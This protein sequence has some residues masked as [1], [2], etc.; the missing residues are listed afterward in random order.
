[1]CRLCLSD[2]THSAGSG[3]RDATLVLDPAIVRTFFMGERSVESSSDGRHREHTHC[4][5]TKYRA[6]GEKR[7]GRDVDKQTRAGKC[8]YLFN[9]YSINR[10]CCGFSV[11]IVSCFGQRAS[12][13]CPQCK[14]KCD[15]EDGSGGQK[16]KRYSSK[17]KVMRRRDRRT[18][19]IT[20]FSKSLTF[21]GKSMDR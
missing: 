3:I 16:Q 21:W 15:W 7:G 8:F 20:M 12:A 6:A 14:Y 10:I 18:H 9:F 4:R 1:M 11:L 13:K 5:T 17:R 19:L 2:C